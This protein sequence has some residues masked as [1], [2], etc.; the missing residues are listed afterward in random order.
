MP[1]PSFIG[2]AARY[3]EFCGLMKDTTNAQDF[4]AKEHT[5]AV[6]RDAEDHERASAPPVAPPAE[7]PVGRARSPRIANTSARRSR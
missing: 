6:L 4:Q 7:K 5:I 3:I 1:Q 2:L